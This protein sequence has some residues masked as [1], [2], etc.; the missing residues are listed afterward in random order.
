[1]FLYDLTTV[2]VLLGAVLSGPGPVSFAEDFLFLFL[3]NTN[4]RRFSAP[5]SFQ[6]PRPHI[7]ALESALAKTIRDSRERE[8][9][10][11]ACN[12]SDTQIGG[13]QRPGG[14]G[15]VLSPVADVRMLSSVRCRH[16]R[17]RAERRRPRTRARAER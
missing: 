15:G 17:R 4:W 6:L 14:R 5:I 3:K 7:F 11:A 2:C 1:M 13:G 10:P 16:R 8:G 9:K 12:R